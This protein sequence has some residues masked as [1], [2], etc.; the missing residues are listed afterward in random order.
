VNENQKKLSLIGSIHLT[1]HRYAAQVRT[2]VRE[3]LMKVTADTKP[4]WHQ[5]HPFTDPKSTSTYEDCLQVSIHHDNNDGKQTMLVVVWDGDLTYGQPRDIR[6]TFTL[7]GEWWRVLA[8]ANEVDR[9][10]KYFCAGKAESEERARIAARAVAI[11]K[12]LVYNFS[13]RHKEN[14]QQ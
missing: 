9:Q 2:L 13:T 4:R 1:G 10:F 7:E 12:E 11:G 8:F 14:S 6:R 5:D 3:G